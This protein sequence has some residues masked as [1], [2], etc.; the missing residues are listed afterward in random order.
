M[1]SVNIRMT[2][3]QLATPNHL[4]GRVSAVNSIFISSSNEMGDIR[5]GSVAS[6]L[7]PVTTVVIGGLA[8]FS[9]AIGGWYL[10]PKLRQLDR[11]ADLCPNFMD[12]HTKPTNME[13]KNEQQ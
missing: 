4:R 10:F 12:G 9:V 11:L 7:G 2:L 3:I 13:Y 1:V 6:I 5:A 8:A